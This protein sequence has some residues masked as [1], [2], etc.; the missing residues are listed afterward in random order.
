MQPNYA[1]YPRP[2]VEEVSFSTIGEAWNVVTKNIGPFVV[3]SLVGLIL[4]YVPVMVGS[5]IGQ[6]MMSGAA[7][8]DPSAAMGTII[9][10]QLIQ[11]PFVIVGYALAS[12]IFGSMS[13]MAL[14]WCRGE[15]IEMADLSFGFSRFAAFAVAGCLTYLITT[16]GTYLCC[17]PGLIAAGGL[18]LTFPFI[19]DRGLSPID[20]MKASWALLSKHLLMAILLYIVAVIV[21]SLGAIA[22]GIGL[23]VTFPIMFVVGALV[24]RDFTGVGPMMATPA[25]TP[26]APAEPAPQAEPPTAEG[27]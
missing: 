4:L 16:I 22:C 19:A 10:S 6:G 3:A 13:Y 2:P 20:A 27:G 11:T 9:M 23:L 5:L 15:A 8:T 1:N 24:Y 21:S 14:K 25:G 7:A 18:M 17:I 12:P 26:P